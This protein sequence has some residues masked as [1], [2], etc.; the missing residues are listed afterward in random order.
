MPSIYFTSINVIT[1]T[2]HEFNEEFY[3]NLSFAIQMT[4]RKGFTIRAIIN[5]KYTWRFISSSEKGR[6]WRTLSSKVNIFSHNHSHQLSNR[7]WNRNVINTSV[8]WTVIF[9][10]QITTN[11]N[12]KIK[13]F[14]LKWLF[15]QTFK[16][17][18]DVNNYSETSSV[19]VK[20][21]YKF[22]FQKWFV[23]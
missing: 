13:H 18:V 17:I 10:P 8:S 3:Y 21:F 22:F 4:F 12:S 14:R 11:K 20:T 7:K 5:T 6:S 1:Q 23:L 2:Q 16:N 15:I 19:D 9:E